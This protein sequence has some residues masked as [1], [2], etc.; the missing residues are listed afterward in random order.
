MQKNHHLLI[1]YIL[2]SL[3]LL[4]SKVDTKSFKLLA[5]FNLTISNIL[6]NLF[7]FCLKNYNPPLF[8]GRVAAAKF[9]HHKLP[10]A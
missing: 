2:T 5:V 6:L 1:C 4:V 8:E 10:C 7:K 3:I 9:K